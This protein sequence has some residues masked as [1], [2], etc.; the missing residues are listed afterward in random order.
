MTALFAFTP[1]RSNSSELDERTVGR[2]GVLR[3]L[4]DALRAASTS[5]ARPHVLLV[6]PR[7]SGKSHALEVALHRARDLEGI[8]VAR[9]AEDAVGITTAADVLYETLRSLDV[10]SSVDTEGLRARAENDL[11]RLEGLVRDATAGRCLVLVIENPNLVLEKIGTEGQQSPRGWIETSKEILLISSA[12]LLS[13]AIQS[14]DQPFFGFSNVVHLEPLSLAEGTELLTLI[15]RR[16]SDTDLLAALSSASGRN[17]LEAVHHLA[18]GSPR[19]WTIFA[20]CISVDILDSLVPVVEELLEKLVPYFQQRLWELPSTEQKLV[21][22][23]GRRQSS[24]TA[25]RLAELSGIGS[26]SVTTLLGRLQ[27]SGWVTKQKFPNTDQRTTHYE[28]R[29]PLLRHHIQFR[30]TNGQEL[31]LIVDLLQAW[32]SRDS[33]EQFVVESPTDPLNPVAQDLLIPMAL[34]RYRQ[35]LKPSA[36]SAVSGSTTELLRRVAVD[37]DAGAFAALPSEIRSII[38]S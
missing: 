25:A 14:R 27:K 12:P 34:R 1:S 30:D 32:F 6:G 21:D 3:T 10:S 29:E 5:T 17:R 15:A 13:H 28:L 31:A 11:G 22:T 20:E 35:G 4:D 8:V 2:Y 23:L 24:T 37:G 9:L 19:L 38:S 7:G 36:R 33:R 16:N 26:D 18:G